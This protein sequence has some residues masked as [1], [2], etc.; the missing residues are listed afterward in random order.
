MYPSVTY[1]ARSSPNNS[2]FLTD[3]TQLKNILDQ[4]SDKV[5]NEFKREIINFGKSTE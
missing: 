4:S 1:L 2:C 5:T 3:T